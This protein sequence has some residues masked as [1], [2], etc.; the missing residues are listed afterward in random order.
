MR[1]SHCATRACPYRLND[2]RAGGRRSAEVWR[3]PSFSP[4]RLWQRWEWEQDKKSETEVSVM[5][6]RVR[7]FAPHRRGPSGSASSLQRAS[8]STGSTRGRCMVRKQA[9]GGDER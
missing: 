9:E 6:C 8:F 1:G 5:S 7:G 3:A 2:G 4:L